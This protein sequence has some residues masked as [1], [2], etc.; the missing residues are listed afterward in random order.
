MK[1]ARPETVGQL[2]EA[3]GVTSK[4]KQKHGYRNGNWVSVDTTV[5]IPSCSARSNESKLIGTNWNTKLT[6]YYMCGPQCVFIFRMKNGQYA[7]FTYSAIRASS[8]GYALER[9]NSIESAF[10]LINQIK[11][12]AY[13]EFE[14]VAD[15]EFEA[16]MMATAMEAR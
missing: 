5:V 6:K 11:N 9:K 4:L 7:S 8:Y 10:E 12:Y 2:L 13:E 1:Q 3:F 14:S 16:F 15:T